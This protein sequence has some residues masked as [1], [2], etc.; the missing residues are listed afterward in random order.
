MTR[1][2]VECIT[3]VGGEY[4]LWDKD[5]VRFPH[6][7]LRSGEAVGD[8]A[9]RLV[10]DWSGTRAP[11]LE[12]VDL[13]TASDTVT[14]VVRAMLV[15]E[16]TGVARRAKRMELPEHVGALTGKYVE[17]ALKTSLNYKLTRG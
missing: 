15:D 13:V 5:G 8:A 10:L 9:R 14:L 6:G 7:E 17:E 3:M 4:V 1:V 2:L 11:K 12:L 16:P